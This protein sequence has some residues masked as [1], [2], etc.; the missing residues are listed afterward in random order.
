MQPAPISEIITP[1]AALT[2]AFDAGYTQFRA[3]YATL[4]ALQNGRGA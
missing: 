4:G 3:G 1:D 2:K